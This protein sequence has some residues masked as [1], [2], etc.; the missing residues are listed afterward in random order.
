MA[1]AYFST[2][3]SV[4]ESA[5][6]M[7]ALFRPRAISVNTSSSR[8][9]S[10]RSGEAL[11]RRLA[12]SSASTT[13]A[14]IKTLYLAL[15]VAVYLLLGLQRAGARQHG[16]LVYGL[17]TFVVVFQSWHEVEHVVKLAQY[18]ALGVNGTG[19]VFGQG[20]GALLALFPIPL[21]HFAYNTVAYVPALVAFVIMTRRPRAEGSHFGAATAA[22]T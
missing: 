19:G 16:R 8:G 1:D 4:S 7:A 10:W 9:G 14:S 21:L 13:S 22:R 3:D 18:L 20:P 11:R 17:L 6:P 2:A 12:E 5:R 15:K